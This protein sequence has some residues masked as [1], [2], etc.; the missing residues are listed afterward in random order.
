MDVLIPVGI[1]GVWLSYYARQLRQ[2]PLL[3]VGDRTLAK[4]IEHEAHS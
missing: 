2:L 3:P 4:A 1:G